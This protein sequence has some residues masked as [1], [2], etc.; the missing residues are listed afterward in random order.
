[1]IGGTLGG[2]GMCFTATASFV[3]SGG[4]GVIGAATLMQVKHR[5]ELLFASLPVLFSVHQAI[6]GVVWL[7]LDGTLPPAVAH[8]AG[9]AFVLYAQGLLPFVIPLSVMLFEPTVSRRRRMLPFVVLGL[10][11]TLFMLWGLVAYPLEVYVRDRSIVYVNAGTN[12][13]WTAV[14]YVLATC[15]SLFF[16]Q[17]PDMVLFGGVNL[18]ILLAVM[19]VKRYAF[20]SVWC[21]YAAVASLIICAYF[22][23]SRLRRPFAYL[24]K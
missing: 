4:L 20:T 24:T 11:L 6:E 7:G 2:A 13:T 21:A 8:G 9:A 18:A 3:A 22:W 23:R 16:S 10:G 14:L 5:R 15:G 17:E 19:A 1:M 12:H